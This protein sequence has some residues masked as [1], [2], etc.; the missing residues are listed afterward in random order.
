M[1]PRIVAALAGLIVPVLT[2]VGPIAA[3]AAD[4]AE[5]HGAAAPHAGASRA[6]RP[7]CVKE[8]DPDAPPHG[9][10][11]MNRWVIVR[12]THEVIQDNGYGYTVTTEATRRRYPPQ[13]YAPQD[14]V[15][16][17]FDDHYT[18]FGRR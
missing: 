1:S 10:G 2:I 5:R 6:A 7:L 4:P 18:V 17:S 11:C 16:S 3:S 15:L 14:E 13:V 8:Q 9:Y 12:T